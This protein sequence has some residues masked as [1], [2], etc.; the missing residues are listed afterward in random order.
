MSSGINLPLNVTV[1]TTPISNGTNNTLLRNEG[2]VVGDTD[3]TVPK[4]DGTAGQVLQTNGA[5]VVSFQTIATGIT[6]GTTAVT[7]GTDGRV[8]FQAGGVIEQDAAFFWDNTNKR[9]G[10][11]ATPASTVRLDVRAQ[12]ALSTDIA[13]RVRNSADTYNTMAVRGNGVID[14]QNPTLGSTFLTIGQVGAGNSADCFLDFSGSRGIRNRQ[15]GVVQTGIRIFYN[16]I[17]RNIGTYISATENSGDNTIFIDGGNNIRIGQGNS[18]TNQPDANATRTIQQM[19]GV[20]PT[21]SVADG[22]QQYSADITAGNAAPHFR[23]ENGAIVKVY[24]ET[25]GV[26]ASTL[27]TG[28]GTPLTDT[29]TFDGYTLKQIVK[30]LRN[31]GLLA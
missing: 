21:T 19:T 11:G 18:N 15:G 5:G 28:V 2:G 7:S 13:F 17:S 1:G 10:I 24:Q 3:Y 25:T 14:F 6:V 26:G 23:T 20:A 22:F 9:L 4:T 29:D 16:S 30:A 8:F 12:G 31:Q 27:V